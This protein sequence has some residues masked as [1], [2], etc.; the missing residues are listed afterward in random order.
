MPY[1]YLLI[2][3]IM[4]KFFQCLDS[5]CCCDKRK[6]KSRNLHQF[7]DVYTGADFSVDLCSQYAESLNI[8]FVAMFY[9]AGMPLMFPIGAITL[10]NQRLCQ[11]IRVA[12]LCVEPP[13]LGDALSKDVLQ[14][15]KFAP[16]FMI[17]NSFWMLDNRQIF[18]NKWHYVQE[19]YVPMRSGHFFDEIRRNQA[20][21]LGYSLFFVTFIILIESFISRE[22]LVSHGYSMSQTHVMLDE[23]LPNFR[24]ALPEKSLR[25]FEVQYEYLFKGYKFEIIQHTLLE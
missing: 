8:V 12:Y 4:V 23:H 18:D 7:I 10:A 2:E 14:V 3:L 6:T 16:L 17:F 20:S 9:G 25:Q 13:Q 19:L 15:L 24:D 22:W 11:R 1:V 21:P 5:G